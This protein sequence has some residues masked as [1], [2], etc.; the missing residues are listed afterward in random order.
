M[1]AH[2][3]TWR[4]SSSAQR[5]YPW[6]GPSHRSERTT[7]SAS[8][9]ARLLG[10]GKGRVE[11]GLDGG[12]SIIYTSGVNPNGQEPMMTA[13]SPTMQTLA[14][15]LIVDAIEPCLEFWATNLGFAK[16]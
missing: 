8:V 16:A 11:T 7:R 10:I 3:S 1:L 13:A 12:T 15:V 14:P 6:R 5:S 4:R 9:T 2:F